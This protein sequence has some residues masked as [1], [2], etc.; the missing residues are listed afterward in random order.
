MMARAARVAMWFLLGCI[1]WWAWALNV[2]IACDGPH[3]QP[4]PVIGLH[5]I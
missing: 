1:V 3:S 2:A 4:F 5:G